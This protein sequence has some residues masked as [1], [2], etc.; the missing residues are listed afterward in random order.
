MNSTK[1]HKVNGAQTKGVHRIPDL[2]APSQPSAT[3]A[4]APKPA[5]PESPKTA[6]AG[7]DAAGKFTAG[8]RLGRGNPHARRM[9][10]LRQAFLSV[11]TEERMKELGEKLYAAAAGGDWQAAKLFLL[12]VVGRPADA[13]NPDTLDLDEFQRLASAPS[14]SRVL[15]ELVDS[16]PPGPAAELLGRARAKIPDANAAVNVLKRESPEGPHS[17]AH[18]H[19]VIG[20]RKAK[21]ARSG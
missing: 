21:L 8:N 7:R 4:E 15:L 20:E 2:A 5:A 17:E 3:A 1:G 12:Y 14:K 16:L 13:V 10:S 18:S 9:A 6:A 19:V 11:A